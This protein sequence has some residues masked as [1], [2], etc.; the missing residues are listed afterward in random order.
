MPKFKI[1][2]IDRSIN[3]GIQVKILKSEFPE[4]SLILMI[5]LDNSLQLIS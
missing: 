1:F 5:I 3:S 4:L 2:L